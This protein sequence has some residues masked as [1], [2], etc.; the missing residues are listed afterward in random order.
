MGAHCDVWKQKMQWDLTLR[1]WARE[2][3]QACPHSRTLSILGALQRSAKATRKIVLAAIKGQ[4]QKLNQT[5]EWG[6]PQNTLKCLAS[7]R[8]LWTLF[9]GLLGGEGH[10]VQPWHKESTSSGELGPDSGLAAGQSEFWDFRRDG[11]RCL[12]TCTELL[13]RDGV[14]IVADRIPCCTCVSLL[15]V[16]R[17]LEDLKNIAR[18]PSWTPTVCHI[19]FFFIHRAHQC[20]I[21]GAVHRYHETLSNFWLPKTTCEEKTHEP[22]VSWRWPIS[23]WGSQLLNF[24][25]F[26]WG[27]LKTYTEVHFINNKAS[28]SSKLITF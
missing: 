17:G 3:R 22:L 23:A 7:P 28:Q 9:W 8:R 27:L 16:V 19:L 2:V 26:S 15:L 24:L 10:W 21:T 14:R 6:L 4:D 11:Q 20:G 5:A 12:V 1:K 13:G 25:S 18:F